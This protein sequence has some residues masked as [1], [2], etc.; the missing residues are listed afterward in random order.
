MFYFCDESKSSKINHLKMYLVGELHQS[1][2]YIGLDLR[3][4]CPAQTFASCLFSLLF[5][6]IYLKGVIPLLD[7]LRKTFFMVFQVKQHACLGLGL[8]VKSFVLIFYETT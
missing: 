2:N 7:Q 3:L 6:C 8:S 5:F 1:R 4:C